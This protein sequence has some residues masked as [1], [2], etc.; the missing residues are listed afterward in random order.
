MHT[1]EEED[2]WST[3]GQRDRTSAG[4]HDLCSSALSAWIGL[5]R[6]EHMGHSRHS[7]RDPSF[8]SA[9]RLIGGALSDHWTPALTGTTA[10]IVLTTSAAGFTLSTS[11]TV[12]L[13]TAGLIGLTSGTGQTAALT[14][15][16][17][18]ARDPASTERTSAIWNICFDIGLGFGALST[19]LV[20]A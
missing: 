3:H 13:M 4:G 1:D 10:L 2:A 6:T 15:M 5:P 11:P 17:R 14:A 12:T 9:G 7:F 20:H 8:L 19:G 16:M 18:R